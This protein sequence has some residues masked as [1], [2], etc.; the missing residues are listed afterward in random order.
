MKPDVPS[1]PK[2]EHSERLSRASCWRT[3]RPLAARFCR[4]RAGG[5]GRRGGGPGPRRA[6]AQGARK[7]HAHEEVDS[8][9]GRCPTR[10]R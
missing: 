4:R 9:S 10:R 5:G 6:G 2:G 1:D 3:R 7:K 8:T